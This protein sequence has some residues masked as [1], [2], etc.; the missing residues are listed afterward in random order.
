MRPLPLEDQSGR[1]HQ[2]VCTRTEVYV[3]AIEVLN[4]TR[5]E[6]VATLVSFEQDN[7]TS[8]IKSSFRTIQKV[9]VEKE[10]GLFDS[11]TGSPMVLWRD[12]WIGSFVRVRPTTYGLFL[13]N[14]RETS[15]FYFEV[16][17]S[18]LPSPDALNPNSR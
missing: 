14:M 9:Q 13:W 1:Q 5:F 8:P 10:I 17:H 18:F 6:I 2:T 3:L 4:T 15:I 7:L 12:Y 11:F 16:S